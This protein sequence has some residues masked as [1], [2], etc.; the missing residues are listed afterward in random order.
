MTIKKTHIQILL[1][2][3]FLVT[4]NLSGRS[5]FPIDE[6]RYATVAW[7]MWLNGDYL[8]PYLNG[9]AYSHKPPLLFWLINLGWGVF[10]VNDWWPRL[11]PSLFALA[12]LL[13]TRK[14]AAILWPEQANIK[15]DA[16]FILL[17]SG[18]WVIYSTAL[19]FDMLIAFFTV[20]GI[21]G[22]LI[23]LHERALKGWLLF[24]LAIGGGLLAKGPTIFLQLLP[25]AL[26]TY[27]WSDEKGLTA[28]NWYLPILYAVLG[29][30]LIALAWA[31]PAGIHGGKE[32]QQAIFWGQT[33]NRMVDS[34]AHNRPFWWYFPILPLLLFPWLLWGAF[35]KGLFN[36]DALR[37]E[38][39]V[40]LCLAWLIPALATF[41]MISG[42]QIHY[43]LPIF[44]AFAL[45]IARYSARNTSNSRYLLLPIAIS[46]F[47]L[48]LI[49][50]VIPSYAN[51][52]SNM[53]Q[54][55]QLIPQ[56][57]GW[58]TIATAALV[59]FLPQKS[60]S[61]VVSKLSII[62]IIV[63]TVLMYVVIHAAGNSYD[64]RPISKKLHELESKNIPVAYLGR[65]PGIYN[66]LGRL[67]QSP[68]SV[69][70]STVAAW[71]TAHP[72]GRVIK[73]FNNLS[74]INLQEVEFAQ[75]QKGMAIAIL[76]H[77]QWQ[78]N[79]NRPSSNQGN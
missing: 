16:S 35:W 6:T 69:N 62:S 14:I 26:L 39:G 66:F 44:P 29:G 51:S 79:K 3:I 67:K 75:S 45:L 28:R 23:A 11:V 9:I 27:W 65:Y 58:A 2:W 73:Y 74:D 24:T 18:L 56:W 15:D 48:G 77:A 54:W 13:I 63:V 52:H 38:I 55:M 41:S 21:W 36:R 33:A 17:G 8:V 31:I 7:N 53:A 60:N 59:Y 25:V 70:G 19:M 34:F 71:F 61:N 20:L 47:L 12:S 50:L 4:V 78:A 32:Y 64:V 42:K 57:L 46:I 40:R 37:S 68:E 1:L 10:G 22:L 76:N 72:D 49:L 43:I 5:Y 30:I